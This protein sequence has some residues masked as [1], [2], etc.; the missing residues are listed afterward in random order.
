MTSASERRRWGGWRGF[1]I[2]YSRGEPVL[3]ETLLDVGTGDGLIGVAALD[4]V[5]ASGTV[6]FSDVSEALL[7]R[8]SRDRGVAGNARSR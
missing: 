2:E 6:I 8:V 1:E 7:E 3:G 5:G 4:L